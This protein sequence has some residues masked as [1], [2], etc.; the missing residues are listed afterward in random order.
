MDERYKVSKDGSYWE[1]IDTK[2]D[3]IEE[4]FDFKFSADNF[5]AIMNK[6]IELERYRAIV[7]KLQEPSEAVMSAV[8]GDS[9]MPGFHLIVQGV[10]QTAVKAAEKEVAR[11]PLDS[12]ATT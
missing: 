9:T 3:V 4:T 2:E 8:L 6:N 12:E 11:A 10:L 5:A 7:N 1:V